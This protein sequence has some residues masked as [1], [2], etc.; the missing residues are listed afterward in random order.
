MI[1]QQCATRA[2]PPVAAPASMTNWH[3]GRDGNCRALCGSYELFHCTCQRTRCKV[4]VS[5]RHS[6]VGVA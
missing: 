4:R 5:Q 6:Y 3:Q 2:L 1:R